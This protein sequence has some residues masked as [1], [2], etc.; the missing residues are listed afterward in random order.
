MQ[1]KSIALLDISPT[2]PDTDYAPLQPVY[3]KYREL[4]NMQPSKMDWV[5]SISSPYLLHAQYETLDTDIFLAATR[6]Y[7]ETWITHYYLPG[8]AL[9]D[10]DQRE[11]VTNAIIKYKQVLHDNDPAYGIFNKEWG[12]PVAD[13]FFHIETRDEP[14]IPMPD[15][16]QARIKPWENKALNVIWERRA[17]Q[18]VMQAPEQVRQRIIDSIESQAFEDNM[19]NHYTRSLR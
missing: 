16:G 12:A 1:K 7:L 3:E 19:G 10:D 6:E 17:Q 18:R 13:A 2:L 4:L 11:H 9:T 8:K 14:S 5:N 15:H